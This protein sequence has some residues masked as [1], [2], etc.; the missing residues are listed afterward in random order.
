LIQPNKKSV[1]KKT[2]QTKQNPHISG[3]QEDSRRA[4]AQE[5][6]KQ[7]QSAL[8]KGEL[9]GTELLNNALLKAQEVLQ[10]ESRNS[11]DPSTQKILEDLTLLIGSAK[12]LS[13]QKDLGDRV[14]R[15][16]D[17]TKQAITEVGKPGVT[18][19]AREATQQALKFIEHLRPLFQLLIESR[20]FRVLIVDSLEIFRRIVHRHGDTTVDTINELIVE[21]YAPNV[22]VQNAAQQSANSFQDYE[23]QLNI[24]ISDDEW[25]GLQDDIT[26]V[27]ATL[28]SHPSYHQGVE[29]LLYLVDTLRDQ[30]RQTIHQTQAATKAEPHARRARE[31]TKDLVAS[32]S[33]QETLDAFVG[34]LQQLVR[35]VDQDERSRRYLGQVREFILS[36]KSPEYVQREEFKQRSR[37]LAN[38]AREIVQ[39]YKYAD[40]VDEFLNRADELIY[41]VR[42][43]EFVNLFQQ[44]AG[45]VADDLSYVD[46]TGNVKLDV[47]MLDKLRGVLLPILAETLKYV[48]IPRIESADKNREYWVDNIVLS[49]Y[50]IVPDHIRV[51]LV[52][53][54][55]ISIR[56]IETKHSYTKL[57]ITLK[58]IRTE[59]K[60][61]D[62]YYKRKSF[63]EVSDSG[64]FS[65]RL[66][67]THGATLK[68]I[69]RV[70]Q[71][72][73]DLVPKFREG[74]SSFYIE[75][76]D[77]NFDKST[78]HHNILL[79]VITQLFKATIQQQIESDVE[80]NLDK[81]IS[82]LGD[83]LTSVLSQFNRPLLSTLD[84][85]KKIG[86]SNEFSQTFEK[87]QE[88][89]E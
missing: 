39:E 24:R 62:F 52:T 86:K 2:N 60:D 34:S 82:K 22:I 9:L 44:H 84:Q 14:Q 23:G 85:V 40:E 10:K 6:L 13:K 38:E 61:L 48:P 78:I 65:L 12:Q 53:D 47:E 41:N 16:A 68:L 70:V 69:L 56:D 63:P 21:G 46:N 31:E 89:L 18:A 37:N 51:Q 20:E 57:V 4:T 43:D 11:D 79:P 27:L 71:S 5:A 55:D 77:I 35:H 73:S 19:P 1:E 33:G 80:K 83:Q 76:L 87:R 3:E 49:A 50:D 15:I 58:Q 7:L 54:N 28:A 67:G 32:F 59:F 36:S 26:R 8:G 30:I 29:N 75:K 81:L 72:P 74:S 64:K 17:E 66:G 88:K 45:I 25:S 42:N